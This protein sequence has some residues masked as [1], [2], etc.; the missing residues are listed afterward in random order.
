MAAPTS[1]GNDGQARNWAV[2]GD[3]WDKP[4]ASNL[5]EAEALDH[6]AALR[7]KGFEN[8]HPA[9]RKLEFT[10]EVTVR[11]TD[12]PDDVPGYPDEERKRTALDYAMA[13]L[14]AA[15]ISE[16]SRLDGFAD[17]PASTYP[18]PGGGPDAFI[19]EVVEL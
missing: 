1:P 18:N 5:T 8:V 16:A 6:V 19:T 4:I 14:F 10:F 2:Y 17:L 3:D 13:A 15:R 9:K 12:W 7:A 11:V